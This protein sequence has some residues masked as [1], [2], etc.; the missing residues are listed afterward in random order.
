MD[1]SK[2]VPNSLLV[3]GEPKYRIRLINHRGKFNTGWTL[4]QPDFK[5]PVIFTNFTD[6]L[7]V[8]RSKYIV[9]YDNFRKLEILNH[10]EFNTS[11]TILRNIMYI[12]EYLGDNVTI[13]QIKQ[14]DKNAYIR[15]MQTRN[16]LE[17]LKYLSKGIDLQVLEKLAKDIEQAIADLFTDI[18]TNETK[19]NLSEEGI[20]FLNQNVLDLYGEENLGRLKRF[21]S[22]E[23][24]FEIQTELFNS[25]KVYTNLVS[26]MIFNIFCTNDAVSQ[27]IS[28][29][30]TINELMSKDFG[31]ES[32]K[33]QVDLNQLI[34]WAPDQ[35]ALNALEQ[36]NPDAFAKM[37]Q[38]FNVSNV[39]DLSVLKIYEQNAN[40]IGI[41]DKKLALTELIRL[42]IWNNALIKYP[43]VRVTVLRQVGEKFESVE[44]PELS[45]LSK[46]RY[47]LREKNKLRNQTNITTRAR[48]DTIDNL[49]RIIRLCKIPAPTGAQVPFYKVVN[50]QILDE[51]AS[52]IEL[53]CYSLVDNERNYLDLI[54]SVLDSKSKN[55]ICKL[56][57]NMHRQ[58]GPVD[59]VRN[60]AEM[61]L[62]LNFPKSRKGESRWD[63]LIHLPVRLLEAIQ[64]VATGMIHSQARIQ[65][66]KELMAKRPDF[67]KMLDFEFSKF[68]DHFNIKDKTLPFS[69]KKFEK[70]DIMRVTQTD[71]I[72]VLHEKLKK[73]L[74]RMIYIHKTTDY[75]INELISRNV[76]GSDIDIS[77][78]RQLDIDELQNVVN[79]LYLEPTF[80]SNIPLEAA[81]R[82]LTVWPLR[83]RGGFLINGKFPMDPKSYRYRNENGIIQTKLID[84][85]EW[86]GVDPK[87]SGLTR[88][89]EDSEPV[90]PPGMS[91]YSRKVMDFETDMLKCVKNLH[92]NAIFVHVNYANK[93]LNAEETLHKV[94]DGFGMHGSIKAWVD[95]YFNTYGGN[96]ALFAGGGTKAEYDSFMANTLYREAMQKLFGV[97]SLE[98]KKQV[99]KANY[100]FDESI[101]V[102]ILR[103]A[104]QEIYRKV[105]D[106][107]TEE[108]PI[109]IGYTSENYPIYSGRHKRIL[110]FLIQHGILGPWYKNRIKITEY[111]DGNFEFEGNLPFVIDESSK[112]YETSHHYVEQIFKDPKYGLPIVTRIGIAYKKTHT[113][114]MAD[115]NK[116]APVFNEYIKKRKTSTDSS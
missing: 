100:A 50:I 60:I 73:D 116:I 12:T 114:M 5:Y 99:I 107:K 58:S 37:M 103:N 115:L 96:K 56:V 72:P 87:F 108:Y 70:L 31:I 38:K 19:R 9:K 67:I 83:A 84:I 86:F 3:Y 8:L 35:T 41:L 106:S 71:F 46:A 77:E 62:G 6:Y 110:A 26:K 98:D 95:N 16:I 90:Y 28:G 18:S 34:N 85:C 39:I 47:L 54:K 92:E 20:R 17:S 40:E 66:G 102:S 80:V 68:D 45:E 97:F 64:K 61:Y 112:E 4:N 25:K 93:L 33:E 53:A 94:I 101:E 52:N 7:K 23:I 32:I 88:I 69:D 104:G 75:I 111:E 11:A 57:I 109:P 27:L 14:T 51:L 63:Q 113:M 59:I 44:S 29:N 81:K 55:I 91:V 78:I 1:V 74:Q 15:T 21:K 65:R 76:Q 89:A 30:I 49:I 43:D 42:K 36:K 105:Y 82:G 13:A 2:N 10:N 48:L 22:S 24:P 79:N